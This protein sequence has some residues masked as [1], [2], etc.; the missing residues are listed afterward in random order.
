MF[1]GFTAPT[2]K[3]RIPH[4]LSL[5]TTGAGQGRRVCLVSDVSVD[6]EAAQRLAAQLRADGWA[7]TLL[8]TAPPD[9]ADA[10]FQGGAYQRLAVLYRPTNWYIQMQSLLA[11]HWL[12]GQTFDLVL[13]HQGFGAGY[14][15][16]M[17]RRLG[18]AFAQTPLVVFLSDTHALALER[19]VRFPSGRN[20][21]EIDFMERKTA[22][23][24]DGVMAASAGLV[25]ALREAGWTLSVAL[26]A[27]ENHAK[28]KT[29]GAWLSERIKLAQTAKASPAKPVFLSVCVA[30]HNRPAWLREC[31]ASL[32]QQTYAPF[33]VVVVDDGSTDPAVAMIQK[34]L[35]PLFKAKGWTWVRQ[36][37]AGAAAARNRAAKLARGAYYL[38]MDD[39]DIAYPDELERFALAAARGGSV[40]ACIL[41]MH[42]ESE[43]TFPP[44]AHLPERQGSGTRPVGWTPIGGD[45][46]L[47]SFINVAGYAHALYERKMFKKLGGFTS[48]KD[49]VFED[50]EF[51]VRALA[52]GYSID[53]V[54][55]VLMLYRRTRQSRSMGPDIFRGHLNSLQ[56]LAQLLPSHLRPLLLLARQEWY[57]RHCQ[58]RDGD[59]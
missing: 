17:A 8:D 37:N 44:T 5:Q 35:A 21:F 24:A 31:I 46:L 53:V 48:G 33:E 11:Y 7:V 3:R 51:L 32:E 25:K 42:P 59:L 56:P 14:Y 41:G 9:Q 43:N 10:G 20:D 34:D 4:A 40:I 39:D 47:T 58:R 18:L 15:S 55:E 45:L 28:T 57:H 52:A 30:T 29:W 26:S 36:D 50:F 16:L 38:F 1:K 13:F 22:E 23:L 54:P 6:S 27:F 19:H 49:V 2:A 12:R